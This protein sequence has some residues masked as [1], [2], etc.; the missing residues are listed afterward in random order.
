MSGGRVQF[1]TTS[2]QHKSVQAALMV[3]L[4]SR[5]LADQSGGAKPRQD[6]QVLVKVLGL[7]PAAILTHLE[8][9]GT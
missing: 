5:I 4:F 9:H 6:T 7:S 3:Y 8:T 2:L 1:R